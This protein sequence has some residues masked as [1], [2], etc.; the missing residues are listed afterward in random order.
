ML[1][2]EQKLRRNTLKKINLISLGTF[3]LAIFSSHSP[4]LS[5]APRKSEKP[6]W[7]LGIGIGGLNQ[8]Y[9]TGTSQRRG[10]VFPVILPIYRGEIFKSDDKGFR[11]ELFNDERYKLD[12]SLDFGLSVDSDEVDLRAGLPDIPSIL[13]IGPSLE[14]TLSKNQNNEWTANFPVRANIGID[15]GLESFGFNFSPNI[16]YLKSFKIGATP[17]TFG[18]SLGPQFGSSEFNDLYYGVDEQFATSSRPAFNADS[19]YNSSRLQ[20]SVTSKKPNRLWVFFIRYDN[21]SGATFDD[22]P[23]IEQNDNFTLGL[24]YSRTILKSKKLVSR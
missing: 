17:W 4:T 21:L 3:F 11:A 22:S 9:Y 24:L 5:A 14:I 18:A 16:S 8:S 19:G 2:I 23:L 20:L 1:K 6:L 15:D 7:E 13:Q 12:I 10:F